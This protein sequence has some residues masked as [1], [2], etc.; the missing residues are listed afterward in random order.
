MLADRVPCA[1]VIAYVPTGLLAVAVVVRFAKPLTTPD[2]SPFTKPLIVS[3]NVGTAAPYVLE[4]ALA[5]T[6]N[7]AGVTVRVPLVNV[8]NM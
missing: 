2:V 4:A 3:V 7:G 5:V 6:V 8:V 1:T